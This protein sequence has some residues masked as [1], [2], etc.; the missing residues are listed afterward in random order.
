MSN[1]LTE[2]LWVP[3]VSSTH[4]VIV[5]GLLISW[6]VFGI[7]TAQLRCSELVDKALLYNVET[8][9]RLCKCNISISC[10]DIEKKT[11]VLPCGGSPLYFHTYLYSFFIIANSSLT[12]ILIIKYL[13]KII[14]LQSI[15][16]NYL[17]IHC[18]RWDP[19]NSNIDHAV[20]KCSLCGPIFI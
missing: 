3:L 18:S 16:L 14:L 5:Q 13:I 11:N 6:F 1:L 7:C 20:P 17:F 2:F 10:L 9:C 15:H 8:S 12:Q 4:I 19:I